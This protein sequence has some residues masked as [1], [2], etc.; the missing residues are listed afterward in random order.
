MAALY[1]SQ[2]REATQVPTDGRT[3]T[4]MGPKHRMQPQEE[5]KKEK[6]R[7]MPELKLY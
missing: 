2:V 7:K 3:D 6:S 5:M 1:T 4:Q